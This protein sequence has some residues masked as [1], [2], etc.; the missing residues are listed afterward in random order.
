MEPCKRASL[1]SY[2]SKQTKHLGKRSKWPC[3]GLCL[4][5]KDV[6]DD[7]CYDASLIILCSTYDQ[8]GVMFSRKAHC[9][10]E[11]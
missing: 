9:Y 10:S 6:H 7:G 3:L 2:L 5:A 8:R 11:C 4:K 1:I